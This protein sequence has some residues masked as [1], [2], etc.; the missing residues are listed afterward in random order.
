[1]SV[2]MQRDIDAL[3]AQKSLVQRWSEREHSRLATY[4]PVL[5]S[6]L[7]TLNLVFLA[8]PLIHMGSHPPL[9]TKEGVSLLIIH[10]DMFMLNIR[11]VSPQLK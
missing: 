9:P 3:N 11:L 2:S 10:L 7:I 6:Q 4:T 1:M 5:A 8:K